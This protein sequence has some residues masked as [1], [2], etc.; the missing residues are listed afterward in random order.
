PGSGW[1]G[2]GSYCESPD[3]TMFTATS[4]GNVYVGRCADGAVVQ[5][6][7]KQGEHYAPQFCAGVKP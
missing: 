2:Y 3:G 7:N 1:E 6:T 4:W 5:L